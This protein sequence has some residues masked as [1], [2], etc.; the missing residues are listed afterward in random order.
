MPVDE[1]FFETWA[2]VLVASGWSRDELKES[3]W[4]LLQLRCRPKGDVDPITGLPL[5]GDGR[6]E[7]RWLLVE[8]LV[9]GDYLHDLNEGKV[10]PLTFAFAI[11][12][13]HLMSW[14]SG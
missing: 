10:G 2:D 13:P 6:I 4:V 11:A 8:E 3:S 5:A 7:E 12:F 9:P 1:F 14:Q